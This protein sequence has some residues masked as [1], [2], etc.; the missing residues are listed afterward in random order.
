M[1][2]I[3]VSA[4][5]QLSKPIKKTVLI[6]KH[7]EKGDIKDLIEL[8]KDISLNDD[9]YAQPS[10]YKEWIRA[11]VKKEELKTGEK[12]LPTQKQIKTE[13]ETEEKLT[14]REQEI[15]ELEKIAD[16]LIPI[17]DLKKDLIEEDL[18]KI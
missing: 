17:E 18:L 15:I 1:G 11:I 10:N 13:A 12:L 5:M 8:Y 14:K 7:L 9:R 4:Q 2:T 6:K 3:S 16:I